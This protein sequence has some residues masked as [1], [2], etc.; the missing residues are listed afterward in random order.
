LKD[1][2]AKARLDALL[3]VLKDQK[4]TLE[5]AGYRWPG[6]GGGFGGGNPPPPNPFKDQNN[7]DHLNSL[8]A[9]LAK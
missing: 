5:A 4:K 3:E 8:Q 2:D 7:H 9:Q 6:E 1:D